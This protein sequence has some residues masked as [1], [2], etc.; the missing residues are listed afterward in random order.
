[1]QGGSTQD[2]YDNSGPL[3]GNTFPFVGDNAFE[4]PSGANPN[5]KIA[6][7]NFGDLDSSGLTNEP[8]PGTTNNPNPTAA[9]GWT[10]DQ[11]GTWEIR[12]SA[13]VNY[14]T[15]TVNGSPVIS[16]LIFLFDN[17]QQ[18]SGLDQFQYIFA[19]AAILDRTAA[20]NVVG[21]NCFAFL[22]AVGTATARTLC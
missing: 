8:G 13:L 9:P 14:L 11:I 17:N 16:D 19:T 22:Q 10:G 18:G 15:H 4:S 20:G 12:L 6:S 21:T 1:M 2:N 7:F 5:T 3:A